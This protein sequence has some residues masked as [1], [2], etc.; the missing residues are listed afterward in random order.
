MS[1]FPLYILKLPFF[2]FVPSINSV[3]YHGSKQVRQEIRRKLMPKNIGPKFPLIITSF[4]VAMNDSK[5]LS[6]YKWKYLV[7]DEVNFA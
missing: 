5:V 3:I 1:K 2:R 6:A 4:E 7:V